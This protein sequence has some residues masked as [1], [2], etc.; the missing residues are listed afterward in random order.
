[1]PVITSDEELARVIQR[2]RAAGTDVAEYEVKASVEDLP[3][4][5]AETIS[6]FANTV[7]GTIVLGVRESRGFHP[8]TGFVPRT[9]QAKCAQAAR[10]EVVPP[11]A[12][13]ST[14]SCSKARPLSWLTSPRLPP[15]RSPATSGGLASATA[16]SSAPGTATTG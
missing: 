4:S 1:M 12:P 7:G 5:T 2:M 11:V 15:G 10:E 13:T 16:R 9:I 6:A 3:K 8:A 14:S